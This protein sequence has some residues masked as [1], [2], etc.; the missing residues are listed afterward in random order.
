MSEIVLK[1]P[2]AELREREVRLLSEMADYLGALGQPDADA[3]RQRFLDIAED[4]REMFLM[5]VIIGEFN[6]GKS[7]FVNA[8]IGA[9]LLKVGVTPTTDT[10]QLIRYSDAHN[11]ASRIR[12]ESIEEWFHPHDF[13]KGVVFVD[14][15]GTGSVFAKHEQVAKGFLH[16][17][18]LVI[19]LLNAKRAFAETEKLYLELAKSYGKKIILVV[20]QAD[21]LDHHEYN[22]VLSFVRTQA[23]ELLDLR[24]EKPFMVSAKKYIAKERGDPN[25]IPAAR[26]DWGMDELRRHL[27]SLFNQVDPAKQKLLAQL[28]M[29]R[30]TGDRYNGG[31]KSRLRLITQDVLQ[32]AEIEKELGGQADSLTKQLDSTMGEIKKTLER[33]K[34]RGN[35]FIDK[36]FNPLTAIRGTNKEKLREEFVS[37][38]VGDA[39]I[40]IKSYSEQY[41]NAVVDGS[42]VYF[43]GVVERLNKIQAVLESE[44]KSLDAATYADQ[45]SAL[46]TALNQANA[47]LLM[48]SDNTIMKQVEDS[49]ESSQTAIIGS[50]AT[51]ILGLLTLLVSL[52]QGAAVGAV[53]GPVAIL[54]GGAAAYF[55]YRKS[56]TDAKAE[57]EKRL[58]ELEQKYRT[59]LS[60]LTRREQARMVQYG[61]GILNPITTQLKGLAQRYQEQSNQLDRF[62][63]QAD[64][65]TQAIKAVKEA[66]D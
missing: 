25:M 59:E 12:S 43:R 21:L 36:R 4:L 65:L 9:N 53:L 60:E 55:F 34:Q 3:D 37:Q 27:R 63:K 48:V 40:L 6:A 31:V 51:A 28:D 15:P 7:T 41:V 20:N 17:S 66:S 1:G 16:R 8:L 33:V 38:V 13:G 14:T 11:T 44:S 29:I 47:H 50:T 22:Q 57:L 54:G 35:E 18:D 46:Q 10:V 58:T 23:D 30:S 32:T 56:I 19:F 39:I 49:L 26:G 24:V 42:R 2:I 64:E 52:A 45:R 5:V 61:Q 62:M